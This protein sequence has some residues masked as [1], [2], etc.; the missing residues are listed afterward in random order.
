MQTDRHHQQ[1]SF[2]LMTNRL[3]FASFLCGIWFLIDS[4]IENEIH[5]THL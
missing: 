3:L 1:C 5:E 4:T 2:I